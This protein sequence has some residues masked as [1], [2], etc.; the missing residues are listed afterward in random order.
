MVALFLLEVNSISV[1]EEEN[2]EFINVELLGVVVHFLYK[3]TTWTIPTP[4]AG[5]KKN[6]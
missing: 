2:V 6:K 3:P 5:T 1:R 4:S